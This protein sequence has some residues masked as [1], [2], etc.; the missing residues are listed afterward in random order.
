MTRIIH[1]ASV[2][3]LALAAICSSA[4]A[5][6]ISLN[7]EG[8]GQAGLLPYFSVDDGRSTVFSI[9]NHTDE[10]KA[11]RVVMADPLNGRLTLGFNVYLSARDTWTAALVSESGD[12]PAKLISQDDSCTVPIIPAGG[13]PLLPYDH[14]GPSDD[15]LGS[16]IGRLRSG[17]IEI[18]EQGVIG[19]IAAAW[20]ANR[21]CTSL[22]GRFF[23]SSIWDESPN[24][25]MSTPTG[26]ISAEAH[27][28]DVADGVAFTG[29]AYMIDGFSGGPRHGTG[30]ESFKATRLT[31]PTLPA[32]A[33]RFVVDGF[34]TV[35]GNRPADAV[36]LLFMA[37][38]LEANFLLGE[39]LDASTDWVVTLPTRQA[40]L[41]DRTGGALAA[42]SAPIAPFNASTNSIVD[43]RDCSAATWTFVSRDGAALPPRETTLCGQVSVLELDPVDGEHATDG[44]TE[45]RA[46]LGLRP[47]VH[48]VRYSPNADGSLPI[49]FAGLPVVARVLTEVSNES[50]Q[51]GVLASYAISS[52]VVRHKDQP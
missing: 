20:T 37:T 29:S 23:D 27:L 21:N 24:F 6:A 44:L 2:Q 35:D 5:S 9:S 39:S 32:N 1:R 47:D 25:E 15:G 34:G 28:I 4:P 31:K 40:Y 13:Q 36:S 42:G 12:A 26:G 33:V 14:T 52:A 17:Q 8:T 51:P 18:I 43:G 3:V 16:D 11:L 10:A 41:D 19:G 30:G 46:I 49:N 50:A 48:R 7:L 45:G 22:V 38:S